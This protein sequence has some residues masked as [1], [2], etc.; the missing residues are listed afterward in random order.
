[1]STVWKQDL[2]LGAQAIMVPEGAEM[3]CAREQGDAVCVWYRCDPAA[4]REPRELAV[5]M[6]GAAAPP[7]EESRYL[8]S[9]H[10]R[11]GTLIVHVFERIKPS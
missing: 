2:H 6:T 7:A 4:P 10:L 5:V 8:G 3:L 9:A 1:V 11:G